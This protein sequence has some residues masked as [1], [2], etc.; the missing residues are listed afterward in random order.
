MTTPDWRKSFY[1]VS[2][3]ELLAIAGFNSS[4]PILPF[5]LQ[6]LGVTDPRALNLWVGACAAVA[7]VTLAVFAPIWGRL[8][9]GYGKRL[10]LL[11]AMIGGAVVIGLVGLTNNPWQVLVLRGLQGA[12]TGTIAAATV[13]VAGIAPREQAG[14]AL[15]LLQTGVYIGT[16]IGPAIGG[17]ISDLFGYPAAFFFSAAML[18]AAGWIVA[19]FVREESAAGP[20]PGTFWARIVPDFTPLAESRLLLAILLLSGVVQVANSVVSPILPLYIQSLNPGASMVGS[21]T[22]LVLGLGALSAA[23]GAAGL[24]RLSLRFGYERMLHICLGGSFLFLVPQ[25]F[26]RTPLQLLLLRVAGGVFLGG[27]APSINAMIATR[28]DR[29]RQGAVYGLSSS[30]NAVGSAIGP[31]IGAAAAVA[32]GYAFSFLVTGGLFFGLALGSRAI[33]GRGR[34]I[35]RPRRG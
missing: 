4:I 29:N 22:G 17:F 14:Y 6:S 21:M 13:L 7:S 19:R 8:A 34:L 20:R 26:I 12:L 15:G 3:A 35:R 10:M 23:L 32:F 25:A 11:R 31:M 5:Y 28:S 24:G 16:S 2:I 18:L 27:T 30:I 33:M 1:A 9:D